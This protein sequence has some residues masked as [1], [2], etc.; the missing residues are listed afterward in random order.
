MRNLTLSGTSVFPIPEANVSGIA[1][2]LDQNAIFVVSEL[3]NQDAEVEVN[4]W[5]ISSDDAI[6]SD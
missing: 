5:K 1:I 2:D 4:V 6:A 3:S